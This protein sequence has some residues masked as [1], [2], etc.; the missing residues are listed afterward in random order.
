MTLNHRANSLPI[1]R[2]Q[3]AYCLIC[4]VALVGVFHP[5]F[6][7]DAA[8]IF[9]V[10]YSPGI[11][12]SPKGAGIVSS[13]S[14]A[15]S[16]WSGVFHDD[17]TVKV[18]VMTDMEAAGRRSRSVAVY[19]CGGPQQVRRTQL[20]AVAAAMGG[21]ANHSTTPRP[22]GCCSRGRFSKR[23]RTTR[24]SRPPM[25]GPGI[26]SPEIRIGSLALGTTGP[27]ATAK[28]NS[29]LKVSRANSKALGL[30]IT[31]TACPTFAS[32]STTNRCR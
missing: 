9:D 19:D 23:S 32:C 31:W 10:V 8:L 24:R 13:V 27:K 22:W 11:L 16:T 26:P 2:S 1:W 4:L 25:L 28:W 15:T 20:C 5:P 29:V 17:I 18:V 12:G 3:Y 14:A 30:P 7:I 21:D 6:R